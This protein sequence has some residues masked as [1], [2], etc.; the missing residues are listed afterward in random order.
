MLGQLF[1]SLVVLSVRIYGQASDAPAHLLRTPGG[2]HEVDLIVARGDPR[3]LASEVKLSAA[4]TDDDV[5][6]LHWLRNRISDDLLDASSSR[7]A[8]RRIVAR[9]YRRCTSC[10][11]WPIDAQSENGTLTGSTYTLPRGPRCRVAYCRGGSSVTVIVYR[12]V[13]TDD[14]RSKA[15]PRSPSPFAS[16]TY[17]VCD[18]TPRIQNFPLDRRPRR[19]RSRTP[20]T[21]RSRLSTPTHWLTS[22]CAV[23][24]NGPRREAASRGRFGPADQRLSSPG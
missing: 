1:E 3:V 16:I 4:I 23:H 2:A 9:W 12:R 20:S 13:N 7:R 5:K 19:T 24:W 14:V 10:T 21:R 17:C 18:A 6:Q 22:R 15:M 8:H 11:D